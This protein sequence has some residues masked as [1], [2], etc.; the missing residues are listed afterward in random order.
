MSFFKP[1]EEVHVVSEYIER[2][3]KLP[4]GIWED[5][6]GKQYNMHEMSEEYLRTS[7]AYLQDQADKFCSCLDDKWNRIDALLGQDDNK[8]SELWTELDSRTENYN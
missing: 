7:M 6:S 1:K 2:L 4:V 3:K 8:Y 5:Y